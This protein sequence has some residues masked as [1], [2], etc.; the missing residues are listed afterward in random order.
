MIQIP[1]ILPLDEG[2]IEYLD[3][4]PMAS[5]DQVPVDQVPRLQVPAEGGLTQAFFCPSLTTFNGKT[6][7]LGLSQERTQLGRGLVRGLWF[8]QEGKVWLP[9][10]VSG[11][12]CLVLTVLP[13][14]SHIAGPVFSQM[15]NQAR[16]ADRSADFGAVWELAVTGWSRAAAAPQGVFVETP[17]GEMEF[18]LDHPSLRP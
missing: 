8:H 2:I 7:V 15:L 11:K 17:D 5:M 12:D 4:R 18:H 9:S 6:L 16:F 10:Q 13:Y 14:R 1:Q 3:A